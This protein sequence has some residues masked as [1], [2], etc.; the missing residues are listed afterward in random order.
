MAIVALLVLLLQGRQSCMLVFQ[1]QRNLM[2]APP[3]LSLPPISFFLS[4]D[5]GQAGESIPPS[6][7]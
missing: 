2:H 4:G 7:K 1:R 5:H 3:T 6:S